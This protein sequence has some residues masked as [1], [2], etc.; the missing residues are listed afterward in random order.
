MNKT[1]E[2]IDVLLRAGYP[3]LYVVSHE[4]HRVAQTLRKIVI[5]NSEKAG[6][7]ST[8]FEWSCTEGSTAFNSDKHLERFEG[9]D[10]PICLLY[11]SPGPRD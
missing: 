1:V 8:F 7:S 2:E 4:E 6:F 5:D 11:T 3:I 10:N 9:H